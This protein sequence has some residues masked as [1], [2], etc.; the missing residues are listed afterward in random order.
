MNLN[1]TT[2]P[3]IT[4]QPGPSSAL[5]PQAAL[6]DAFF[7]GF[8][9][10]SSAL[11]KYLKI[12]LSIYVPT[13]LIIG[14]VAFAS[15][16]VNSYFWEI[17][18]KHFMSIADIRVDDEM[19]NMVMNWV[20]LQDFSQR[21]RRFVPTVN[22][23][24]RNWFLFYESLS[25][26]EEDGELEFE[27]NE[28]SDPIPKMKKKIDKELKYTPSCGTHFFWYK[29]RVFMFK[30]SQ[31]TRQNIV[32]SSEREEIS[33]SSFGRNPTLLK[34]LLNECRTK[35][36]KNDENKTPIYRGGLKP[37]TS[38]PT[39]TRCMSRVSRPFSTVVLDELVKKAL[40]EDMRDYLHPHTRRYVG[41]SFLF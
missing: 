6:L 19:Y 31:N 15:K 22:L 20:S 27:E 7:P 10:V 5:H 24:S 26:E 13:I 2:F 39:W 40:L 33:L 9:L 41:I 4:Q 21:S 25:S 32:P 29:G 30:R 38:E 34:E 36:A 28:E 11:Y 18:G 14:F 1:K 12:D 16:Y 3:S 8:S 37:G 23:N 17:L 35:F